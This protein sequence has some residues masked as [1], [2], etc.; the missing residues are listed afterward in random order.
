MHRHRSSTVAKTKQNYTSGNCRYYRN[1][2]E[3]LLE[4]LKG[5][6]E[7]VVLRPA[8]RQ[9][10]NIRK[11]SGPPQCHLPTQ[12]KDVSISTIPDALSTLEALWDYV[13]GQYKSTFTLHYV[14]DF[15][16]WTRRNLILLLRCCVLNFM[17]IMSIMPICIINFIFVLYSRF[18]NKCR[19]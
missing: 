2:T 11:K 15:S 12:L 8:K 7:L 14:N 3:K 5:K 13:L 10:Q 4:K 19:K 6:L 9:H 16:C 18:D 1:K 17:P